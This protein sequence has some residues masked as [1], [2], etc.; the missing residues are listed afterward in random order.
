M[1]NTKDKNLTFHKMLTS[2]GKNPP[3]IPWE[4]Y[5]RPLLKRNSFF[6]LNGE[7]DFC[8]Q[9]A[10][11]KKVFDGKITVPFPPESLLSGVDRVFDEENTLIY[12]KK[13]TL[14][15]GFNKGRVL[16]HFGA[17]DQ[18]AKVYVNGELVA[19][20]T[21]GYIP[22]SADITSVLEEENEITVGVKDNLS[23]F[24][25]PYGKQC[26]NRGGMWYTPVSGIWQ[27]VWVESVPQKYIQGVLAEVLTSGVK[28]KID[29]VKKADITVTTPDGEIFAQT[30]NGEVFVKLPN[31]VLWSPE[32]PYLYDY[33]V[34]TDADEV[35]SY[36]AVRRL[37]IK[38]VDGIKRL[39]L[40][41]KP[42]FFHGLLDQGYFSDGIF[43]PAAPSVYTQEI[44]RIKALGFNTLRKHI[45][46]EPQIFYYECDRLGVIVWQDMV[47]NGDYKFLRD[48]A[49]PTAGFIRRKDK[50]MHA[51]E[52]TRAAFLQA[53]EETVAL[54]KAH[55]SICY[56]TVFNEGWGQFE[57]E[58]AYH[59]LKKLDDTR[60][61]DTTSGWFQCGETDVDSRHVYFSKLKFKPAQKPIVLSE[62]GGCGF[63]VEGHI[64]NT[65]KSYGYGKCETRADFVKK[66][67]QLYLKKIIPAVKNGLCASI[68]TQVSDVEDE[69]N[70]LFTYDREVD[71][72]KP[73]E[74][75]D[76]STALLNEMER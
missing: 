18:I 58:K 39:C 26:K 7:W 67:R 43:T 15:Q 38:S 41:G 27:T 44:Q 42:Y 21:G 66:I 57:S 6:C 56:W 22:F 4:E 34:K 37:E 35:G 74:F 9:A 14:P 73:E 5:P 8:V 25:L 50:N 48:T 13:F 64:F 20:H 52:A 55:P 28:F 31:P 36:F 51:D 40:N 60:F 10:D 19:E 11:G 76:V 54:L 17:V 24:V 53:M 63:A 1:R 59:A 71:K 62:F 2:A 75:L 47:N 30:E 72:I 65:F 32:N 45:K 33:T 16:L 61:I 49:L 68:Y 70:G 46:I 69:L 12:R 23:T 3:E 29:G